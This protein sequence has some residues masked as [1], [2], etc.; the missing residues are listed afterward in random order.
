MIQH[1]SDDGPEIVLAAGIRSP[2]ARAGGDFRGED[3]AHLGAR[4]ARELLARTGVDPDLLTEVIV[5]CVGPPHDQAN[6]GRVLGLRAGVPW[7]VPARTVG[8]NCA[9]GIEAVTEAA[10]AILA[11]FGDLYLCLGVEVMSAYPLIFGEPMTRLF[12]RLMRARS[13]GARLSA[14]AS[15]RPR[16]LAP[17]VECR[18]FIGCG[19]VID[20]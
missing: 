12:G 17:R 11:G 8:R 7:D 13:V 19:S 5:G 6:V 9:S 14:M 2:W 15:F 3:A 18:M 20:T 1:S 16:F 4:V 10:T